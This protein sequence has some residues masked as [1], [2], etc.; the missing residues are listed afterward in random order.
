MAGEGDDFTGGGEGKRMMSDWVLRG[1]RIV[2]Q[3]TVVVDLEGLDV[4]GL[5]EEIDRTWRTGGGEDDENVFGDSAGN[6]LLTT[7]AD[8]FVVAEER[9]I[10][11]NGDELDGRGSGHAGEC[12]HAGA[13]C[14]GVGGWNLRGWLA[15]LPLG[16][17]DAKAFR[18]CW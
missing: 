13:G 17:K 6:G 12:Y 8:G 16:K 9:A 1:Q 5:G 11:I 4:E 15:G 7:G 14:K 2:D 10:E 18:C 3:G